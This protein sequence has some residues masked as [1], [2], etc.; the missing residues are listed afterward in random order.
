MRGRDTGRKGYSLAVGRRGRKWGAKNAVN[1]TVGNIWSPW[2][3][4]FPL[5]GEGLVG[6]VCHLVAVHGAALVAPY[7]GVSI[8]I[9]TVCFETVGSISEA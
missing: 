6:E 1:C 2:F 5:G 7:G 3:A 9:E 4:P 8:R